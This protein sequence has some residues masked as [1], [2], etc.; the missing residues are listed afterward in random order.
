VIGSFGF[1]YAVETPEF[2]PYVNNE[3]SIDENDTGEDDTLTGIEAIDDE[4][5]EDL[6]TE[7]AEYDA[8]ERFV[9][10]MYLDVLERQYDAGG[11]NHWANEL[12]SGR[13]TGA[14]FAH[15]IFFSTEFINYKVSDE[16]FLNRMYKG[17]MDRTPDS[18]GKT[19]WLGRL[20]AGLP[21]ENIFSGFV[22]SPEFTRL[23]ERA[24]IVR[25]T[26]TPPQGGMAR[27]F[28]TRLYRTTLQREPDAS[29]LSS[30]TTNLVNGG[31]G[32]AVAHGFI[33]STEMF[34]RN[35][36]DADFVEILYE[37][38]MGRASDAG[39]KAGWVSRLQNGD[40]RHSVFAGFANSSEFDRICRDHGIQR[41]NIPPPVSPPI[42]LTPIKGKI[43]FLD[44]G[45]GTAGSPGAGGYN[46]AVAMLGLAGRI[47]PL[48]EAQGATVIV[49]RTTEV[50]V[51]ISVRCAMINI[52]AL[53]AV[54]E[55]TTNQEVITEINRLLIVMSSIIANPGENGPIYMN[56]DPFNPARA[57]HPDLQ[58]VFEITNNPVI[59]DKFLVIS[60]HS[61]AVGT[62]GSS[63]TRGAEVYY[64]SPNEIANTRQYYPD[65]SFTSQS[66]RFADILLD[67]IQIAGIPRRANGLRAANY[68]MI[69]EINVPAVLTE[70]GFHTNPT[71]RA[72]LS[73]PAFMARLATEYMYAIARYFA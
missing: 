50:N 27:V 24:G 72:L 11:L 43:I 65:F 68:A 69:R 3:K 70:N 17:L 35:L 32:A 8:I 63:S 57:I 41:G 52:R 4:L 45:H 23:C 12:R 46:E 34:N 22:N 10:R 31:S 29:G 56:L 51:P 13:L 7:T 64:I 6:D 36:S 16:D 60:L 5:P 21:R 59:R 62:G 19:H 48:L 54:K 58:S 40:T 28:V 47:R 33:F 38:L 14:N 1:V 2:F 30:W 9:S 39:G 20:H 71:D 37:A 44:P 53:E 61:N 67:H 55:T 15:S 49:T 25:G 42:D 18:G 73:D 26:Y 66:R